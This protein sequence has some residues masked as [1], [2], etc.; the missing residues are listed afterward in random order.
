V[1]YE[2]L[3]PDGRRETLLSVPRYE[4]AWQRVYRFAQPKPLPKGTWILITAGYDNSAL[5]P[6]NPDP[7]RPARWGEQTWDEMFVPQL[8]V[9]RSP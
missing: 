8:D 4:F 7:R 2:A 3:Y 1:K 9:V 6:A 5:N